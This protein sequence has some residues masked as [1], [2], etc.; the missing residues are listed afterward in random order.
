MDY[1]AS[2]DGKVRLF[3]GDC[4]EVLTSTRRLCATA[5][6][7]DPPYGLKFMSRVWDYGVPGIL[8]WKA[9]RATCLPGAPLC[10]F[11]GTRTHHR[12]WCAI[13]DAGWE[14]RDCVMW[15]Y[16]SGF[17]KSVNISKMLD[18][19]TGAEREV[20]GY[21]EQTGPDFGD[22]QF[23]E[24]G[25]M[26]HTRSTAPRKDIAITAPATEEAW[27]WEGWGTAL[28]PA[29]E[30]ICLAMKPLRGTFVDNALAHGVAGLNIDGG[31]IAGVK[32]QVTQ[33]INS[34]ATSFCVTKNRRQSGPPTQ[35]RWPANVIHD[36]SEEVVAGFP[37][38]A[39]SKGGGGPKSPCWTE[40]TPRQMRK[41]YGDMV[42]FGDSGSAA[43]FF[44]CA[45]ASRSERNAGCEAEPES[46]STCNLRQAGGLPKASREL[47][48][49]NNHPT[50]KPLNLM[51]YLL[52]LVTMP[53]HNLILDPFMGSGSTGVACVQ[54]GLPFVGM[55]KGR[56]SFEIAVARIRAARFNPTHSTKPLF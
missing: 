32:P 45:K 50:V 41:D 10:A 43:R 47:R 36:G 4:L 26:I 21:R 16:G 11:G 2:E 44:Y 1:W 17:P 12:L 22:G 55:E 37:K 33:G 23:V 14:I 56:K 38:T 49:R 27:V 39:I 53:E 25:S 28:K 29:W 13:E 54:L 42:G 31:R 3:R 30:P 18:K 6:V 35:G 24:Q 20:V 5:V 34:N 46:P 9:I 48:I 52:T 51:R 40:S 15:L 8:F 19:V 7:T